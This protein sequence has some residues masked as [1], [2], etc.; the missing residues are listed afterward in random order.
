MTLLLIG[1][2]MLH[3][4]LRHFMRGERGKSLEGT[5]STILSEHK[6]FETFE[7]E[8]VRALENLDVRVSS[9]PRGVGVVRFDAFSGDGSGGMQSFASAFVSE[10]GD[11]VVISSLHARGGTR[12]FAKPV[13]G[14][15]SPLELTEEEQEAISSSRT[16]ISA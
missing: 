3:V 12:I 11:G 7:K 4:R 2:F 10:K 8:V 6:E 1:F 14:F 15:T 5:L 16:K 9:S 13:S